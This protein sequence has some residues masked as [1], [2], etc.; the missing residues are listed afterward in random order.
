MQTMS[1]LGMLYN[2]I[3]SLIGGQHP[4]F[5]PWHFQWLAPKDVYSDLKRGLPQFAGRVL[6][7]GCGRE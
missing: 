3:Y 1:R 4:H 7:V 5:R 6:D 2:Q